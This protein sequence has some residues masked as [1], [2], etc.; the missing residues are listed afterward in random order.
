MSL[1]ATSSQTVGPFFAIGMSYRYVVSLVGPETRGERLTLA[2][3]VLDGDRRPV[4][5][6]C[7]ELW[8][9][10]AEGRYGSPSFGGFGRVATDGDGGFRVATI[11]PGRVPGPDGRP[12][13]PHIAVSIFARGM[14][15]RLATR[16]YFPGD[17]DDSVLER[18]P[19]ARRSTLVARPA[20]DGL[21]EWDVILQGPGETVFFEC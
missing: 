3:R 21:Y 18:V 5:D 1:H 14:L 20:G 9:A 16:I 12:M 17:G 8:Q 13:A 6:G 2:G 10:D 4:P 11:R 7:L 15:R 19:P